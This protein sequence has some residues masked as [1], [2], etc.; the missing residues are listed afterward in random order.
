MALE[1]V[2]LRASMSNRNSPLS[3]RPT[4]TTGAPVTASVEEVSWGRTLRMLKCIV[5]GIPTQSFGREHTTVKSR[6][7]TSINANNQSMK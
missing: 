1:A 7:V 3:E 4:P 2:A 6:T 5:S